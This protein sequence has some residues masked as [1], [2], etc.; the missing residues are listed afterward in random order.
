MTT[1][2]GSESMDVGDRLLD[3]Q[4]VDSNGRPFAKVDDLELAVDADGR[5]YVVAILCGPGALGPRFGGR[6]GHWVVAVWRRLH[7]AV[8]P[9]PVRIPMSAVAKIDSAVNLSVPLDATGTGAVANWVAEHLI[10][11]IPGASHGG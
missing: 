5:P 4:V 7:P 8:H 6:L 10:S 1:A 2:Q 3:R 11:K 9:S